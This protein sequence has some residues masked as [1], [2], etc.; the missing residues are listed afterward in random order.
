MPGG[1][2]PHSETAA[3]LDFCPPAETLQL[4]HPSPSGRTQR[5]PLR[6]SLSCRGW[7]QACVWGRYRQEIK[8]WKNSPDFIVRENGKRGKRF[9]LE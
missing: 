6:P 3:T 8:A 4:V 2:G 9:A 5:G 1:K 7:E